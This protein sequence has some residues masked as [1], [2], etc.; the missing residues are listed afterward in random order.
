[1]GGLGFPA[2]GGR[3]RTRDWRTPTGPMGHHLAPRQV[4]VP[5]GRGS[6]QQR[7]SQDMLGEEF[8]HFGL[9]RLGQQGPRSVAHR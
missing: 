4:P 6:G 5:G 8:G 7:T 9:R 2:K 1:M 3:A